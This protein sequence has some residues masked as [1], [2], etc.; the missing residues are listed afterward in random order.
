MTVQVTPR[1]V[2]AGAAASLKSRL[3]EVNKL[4]V[5][6]VPDGD[7][8]TN[9]SLTLESV[10]HEVLALPSDASLQEITKAATHGSLMG[11]RG[12][13]G[14]ILSQIVR[15]ACE[16]L[17]ASEGREPAERLAQALENAKVIAYQAVRKPVEGTI[18]TVASDMALAAGQAAEKHWSFDDALESVSAAAHA[19]VQRTPDLLPVL[20]EAGVVDSGGF[21]LA[22]IIDAIVNILL[23]KEQAAVP[24]F[25]PQ[26]V[27]TINPVDDWDDDEYLYCTEFLLFGEDVDR[28]AVHDY[29]ATQGGSEL[30]V[31]D[32]GQYKIHV[33]TDDPS[34]V[35]AYALSQGEIAEVHIHN[36]RRQQAERGHTS[37]PDPSAPK[38]KIA[39]IAVSAGEGTG[40]ILKSLGVDVLVSG[41]Q[42]MNPATQDF[43]AA[44]GSIPAQSYVLLPN[45]S[46]IVMAATTAAALIEE[47]TVVIPTTSIPEAFAA[48]LAFDDELDLTTLQEEMS[49][50]AAE[51]TTAEVTTAIKDAKSPVGDIHEGD[52]IGII[53]SKDIRAKGTS[54]PEVACALL[55]TLP[56]DSVD[57]VTLLTGADLSPADLDALQEM[58]QK[59]HPELE[60]DTQ[61]GGQPLYPLIMAVE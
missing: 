32:Y 52:I 37:A 30:V 53:G 18:L 13:S 21:G 39:V 23:G 51:V 26:G 14:V 46:N 54:I 1:E 60:Y 16:G 61:E 34:K 3:E 58:L 41:G 9:M 19:S 45:N 55:E 12:N 8:G 36:M 7:T 49:A 4:N 50:A 25:V 22:I 17:I 11:A 57:T 43:V 47:P 5:F 44:A 31:G 27:L 48:L 35:L 59:T 40:R 42:T 56:L 15:G 24:A 38:K 10:A 29:I 33:H 6:P 2:I 20:K 28:E